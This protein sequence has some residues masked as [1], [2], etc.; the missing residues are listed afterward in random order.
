VT[1]LIGLRSLRIGHEWP[2]LH[3]HRLRGLGEVFANA[4]IH[5][6]AQETMLKSE[7]GLIEAQRI[8]HL[9]S[10]DWDIVSGNLRWSDEVYRIFGLLPREVNATYEAFL[11]SVHPDDHQAVDQANQE[12]ISDPDKP[13]SIVYRVVRP[14]GIERVVRARAEVLFDHD[15][16]PV[17]MIG[18][19]HD[20]TE[21]KH[22][23]EALRKAFDEIKKLKDQL[24]AEN[25]Y[26]REEVELKGGFTDIIGVSNPIKYV[27]YRI[28]QVA[29]TG[30]TVLL[31][32]ETG[33]GKGV[34]ARPSMKRATGKTNPSC[35]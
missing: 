3:I 9:G 28:R 5:R 27:I 11:A 6:R 31:T 22:A 25:I 30:T 13:Y 10:W 8:A 18:T 21:R 26:L 29:P 33:S 23:E 2:I 1:H 34:F 12:A 15:R 19:V 4:L 20:I 32:G 16:R 17:R 14:D 7:R 24:E 35:T